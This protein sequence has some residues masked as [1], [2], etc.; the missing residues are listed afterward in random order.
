MKKICVFALLAG[1]VMVMAGCGDAMAPGYAGMKTLIGDLGKYVGELEAEGAKAK[2]G[3]EAA[4]AI[5]KFL[6]RFDSVMKRNSEIVAKYPAMEK[7]KL[8]KET[9]QMSASTS[10][11]I[12]VMGDL[13]TKFPGDPD[14]AKVLNRFK[15]MMGM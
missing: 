5:D 10:K 14:M 8:A 6:T 11:A 7:D 12:K 13:A 2:N 15:K 9:K 1:V 4:A 3:K